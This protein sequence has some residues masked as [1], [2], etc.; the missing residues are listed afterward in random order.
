MSAG[1]GRYE[2]EV[3][4]FRKSIGA[5][6]VV[7]AVYAGTKGDAFE[8]QMDPEVAQFIPK[9]LREIADKMEADLAGLMQKSKHS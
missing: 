7:V 4:K 8:V 9:V 5:R 2:A 1:G 3:T 6:G